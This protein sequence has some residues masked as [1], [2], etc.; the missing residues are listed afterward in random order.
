[1]LKNLTHIYPPKTGG[2]LDFVDVCLAHQIDAVKLPLDE[3]TASSPPLEGTCLLHYSGYGYAKRGAP[4]WLLKKLEADRPRI[5]SLG[6]FFHE[7]YASGSP[8]GSAFWLSPIQRLIARRL[9][10]MSDFW[11]TNREDSA[12][13]LKQFADNKPN[14]VLPVFSNVGEMAD[15]TPRKLP[16]IVVFGGAVL[17]AATYRAAGDSLFNWARAQGLVIHDI[18]PA[19]NEQAITNS[20]TQAGAII[21]GRLEREEAS[22]ILSDAS[23]GVVK[24]PIEYVAKSSVYAAYCAHGVCPILISDSYA[25]SDGLIK[26]ENYL[27]GLPDELITEAKAGHVG[28]TAW[29]WYQPHRVDSHISTQLNLLQ[30]AIKHAD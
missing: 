8:W 10:E 3:L 16:K 6:V 4:L 19:M 22:S 1:M 29:Q 23:F 30:Q 25:A 7:L 5:K 13:W 26:G 18:G 24:Y 14:A 21:H 15:D 2:V 20:L 9:S 12:L 17:R 28:K 27:A 11:I